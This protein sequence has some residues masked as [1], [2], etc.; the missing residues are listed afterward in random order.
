[1]LIGDKRLGDAYL[2]MIQSLGIEVS[3]SKTHISTVLCEF[4]KRWIY[5]KQ[6]I[7]PFPISALSELGKSPVS[8]THL[9]IEL[10]ERGWN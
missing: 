7:S 4:A 3:L 5:K 9:F 2:E 6:E 1:M 8:L 10:K